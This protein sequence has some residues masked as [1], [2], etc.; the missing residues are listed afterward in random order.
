[1]RVVSLSRK[2]TFDKV[3]RS[4]TTVL[5]TQK[6]ILEGSTSRNVLLIID[7]DGVGIY[8]LKLNSCA[9]SITILSR[10]NP[11]LSM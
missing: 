5:T 11:G 9:M 3:A 6:E 8:I 4:F 2:H 10:P 7:S 1:M